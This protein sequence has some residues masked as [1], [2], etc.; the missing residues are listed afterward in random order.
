MMQILIILDYDELIKI[1]W[2]MFM[3]DILRVG[4]PEGG[5]K[6]GYAGESQIAGH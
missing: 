2:N 4:V 3:G 5:G 6:S 1:K